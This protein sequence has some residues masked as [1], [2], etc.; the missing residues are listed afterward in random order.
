MSTTLHFLQKLTNDGDDCCSDV[1]IV[2]VRE[3]R[4]RIGDVVTELPSDVVIQRV[5]VLV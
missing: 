5:F 4:I 1:L 2:C 3:R